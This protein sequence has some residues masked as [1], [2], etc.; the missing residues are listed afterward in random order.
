M[1]ILQVDNKIVILKLVILDI[2]KV[3][4]DGIVSIIYIVIVVDVKGNVSFV[5]VLVVWIISLGNI[6]VMIRIN[7]LGKVIVILIS[8]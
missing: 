3:V 6:V 5:D 1:L 7:V 4:V 8:K 2:K